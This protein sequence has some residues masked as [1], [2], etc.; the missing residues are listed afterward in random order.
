MPFTVSLSIPVYAYNL[1]IYLFHCGILYHCWQF[2]NSVAD[3]NVIWNFIRD[4]TGKSDP[5]ADVFESWPIVI[6]M[7]SMLLRVLVADGNVIWNFIRDS[8]GKSDPYG[9]VF[10]SW[11]IV[12]HMFSMLLRV[13]ML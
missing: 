6:H 3:G 13:L 8:T 4:S 7:F 2:V 11:P 5:Y 1:A 12:I 9:D 10:E